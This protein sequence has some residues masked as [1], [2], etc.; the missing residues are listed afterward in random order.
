MCAPVPS[1]GSERR[2][3][4]ER[5]RVI[6]RTAFVASYPPRRDGIA[7]YT[8]DLAAATGDREIAV[9]LPPERGTPFPLE[10][11]HRIRR[12]ERAD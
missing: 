2:R 6:G 1:P 10:V 4:I 9:L 7:T 11:H 3:S 8:R 12:D 5:T